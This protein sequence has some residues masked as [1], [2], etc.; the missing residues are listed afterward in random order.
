LFPISIYTN[1]FHTTIYEFLF[2]KINGKYKLIKTQ[3]FYTDIAGME[4]IEYSL[5]APFFSFI[6]I[7]AWLL[8]FVLTFVINQIILF[9][10]KK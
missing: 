6:V 10:K 9:V 1:R 2:Q 7:A 8:S 3:K 5:T 4:G